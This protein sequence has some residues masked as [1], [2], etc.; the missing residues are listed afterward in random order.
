MVIRTP[1]GGGIRGGLYHSQSPE[2]VL[3]PTPG[4]KVVC[5]SSP[6]DAKGAAAV[7]D[8][9]PRPGALRRAQ[10][11]YR[12]VKREVPEGEY[13]VPLSQEGVV[14]PGKDV[15]VLAWGAML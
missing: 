13:T 7:G 14:R 10:A 12:A 6:Y 1:V 11:A 9:R 4:L 5:P 15:T 3:H 2:G 8:P